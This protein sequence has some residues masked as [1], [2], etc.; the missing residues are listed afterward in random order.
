MS[1]TTSAELTAGS[2]DAHR[3]AGKLSKAVNWA[4]EAA[5]AVLM[6]ALVSLVFVNAA[7]RYALSNPLPW[8]EDLVVN[9]LVW[10]AALGIVMAGMR[11]TLICCDV[12][13]SRLAPATARIVARFCAGLGAAVMLYCAWLTFQYLQFFGAD[14]SPVLG[15]PKGVIIVAVLFSLLGLAA[16]LIAALFRR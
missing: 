14:R 4:L 9:L 15:I 7:S 16:T 11:Q 13:T 5:A 2:A 3:P 6:T 12:V 8:T 1:K 10:L